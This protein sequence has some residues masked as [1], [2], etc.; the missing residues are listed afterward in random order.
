MESGA[1][2]VE[3]DGAIGRIILNRPDRINA[4]DDSIRQG[5]PEALW[6]LDA[7]GGVRAIVV[8]GNGARGFC[9]GADI[10]E[11]RAVETPVEAHRRMS[12]DPWI[13]AFEAMSTPTI[14]AIHGACMGGG[15][16][17]ALACDIRMASTD[18]VFAL[19]ETGLGLIPGAG[20]TQRL[21]RLIGVGAA[22]DLM[23]SNDRINGTEAKRLNIVTRLYESTETLF[24]A[25]DA[26]AHRIAAKPPTA[27]AFV[28]TATYASAE[29][30][31]R[32]GLAL[33]R[34]L[35]ALL[36]T[37]EDRIEAATAFREKRAPR[38]TAR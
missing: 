27:T 33:E 9:A 31:L 19:P 3:R 23:L 14:A 25:A 15:F 10:R 26:L 21:P 8:R 20:G 35:F 38:F 30:D 11:Q 36:L 32:Q 1:I 17:I 34:H 4:I 28:R 24:E 5:L 2:L 16:E 29:L 7:D 37:T 12:Q 13:A 18:A 6:T 22:L